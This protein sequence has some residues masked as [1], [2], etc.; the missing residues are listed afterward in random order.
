MRTTLLSTALSLLAASTFACSSDPGATPT[1]ADSGASTGIDA[2]VMT[3]AAKNDAASTIDGGNGQPGKLGTV[4][5]KG[6]CTKYQTHL[7]NAKCFTATVDGCSGID[8]LDVDVVVAD[9]DDNAPKATIVWSSGSGGGGMYEDTGASGNT[10]PALDPMESLRKKGYRIIE[11]AWAGGTQTGQWFEGKS[12]PTASACRYATLAS[13]LRSKYHAKGSFCATG[14]SGGS[15]EIG[16]SLTRWGR[17]ATID[18]ALLTSGPAA[19][20]EDSCA[21]DASPAWKTKCAQ[22]TAGKTWQC[23]GGAPAC[24]YDTGIARLID[25]SYSHTDT[26]ADAMNHAAALA[27]DSPLGT[28]AQTT[29]NKTR[30]EQLLAEN[31]CENGVVPGALDFNARVTSLGATPK[32]TLLPDVGHSMQATVAGG[33]AIEAALEASCKP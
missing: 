8:A 23:N 12:G 1:D 13:Y 6:A 11:R 31:D 27:A 30:I 20:F 29:F 26:C 18:Y 21:G 10:R 14:N 15:V 28:P 33:D 7:G 19:R 17:E 4:T 25:S 3:D 9:P 5:E 16:Y 2:A 24:G 32:L 22:L